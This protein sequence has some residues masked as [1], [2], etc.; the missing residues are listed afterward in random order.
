MSFAQLFVD[1]RSY[2]SDFHIINS[3]TPLVDARIAVGVPLFYL[4][5][6]Y[7]LKFLMSKRSK[8]FDLIHVVAFHN[9][10]SCI[11]SLIMFLGLTYAI[12]R[13]YFETTYWEVI[14]DPECIHRKGDLVFWCYIFYVSKFY[15]LLDSYFLVLR[16]RELNFLHVYHH[17]IVIP[18]FYIYNAF[19]C[20][21]H[22]VLCVTNTFVHVFMYYYYTL[23][24]YHRT[25]WWKK[26]ITIG[27]M[28]QFWIDMIFTWQ[29]LYFFYLGLKC[30]LVVWAIGFGH[31]VGFSFFL[32]FFELFR[33]TYY[34]T[35]RGQKAKI[36]KI[37]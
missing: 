23:A 28:I 9:F 10:F 15:E 34:T 25:V 20:F 31:A 19:D 27:Q 12:L 24:T 2:V 21:A 1:L 18:L 7:F 37:E 16:K 14:C 11:G 33:Q 13:R 32:L 35:V 22:F 30:T 36:E 29:H 6:L 26:Y 4:S 8:G 5:S 3:E 17:A